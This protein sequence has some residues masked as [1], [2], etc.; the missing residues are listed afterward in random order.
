MEILSCTCKWCNKY[1]PNLTSHCWKDSDEMQNC[2]YA[3]LETEHYTF[4]FF[5][6]YNEEEEE[7]E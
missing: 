5:P 7:E 3:K 4:S 6:N 2:K 1:E